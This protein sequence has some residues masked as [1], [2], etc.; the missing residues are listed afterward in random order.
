LSQFVAPSYTNLDLRGS[1]ELG[2]KRSAKRPRLTVYINNLLD[3]DEQFP[4]GYS[5]QFLNRD[6][7]GAD[8]LDGLTF[9][10]PLATRSVMA[11]LTVG[12]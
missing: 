3:D 10:Y 2:P 7:G 11:T 9:Y 6:A 1:M 8:T 4:G 12:F 5:Y